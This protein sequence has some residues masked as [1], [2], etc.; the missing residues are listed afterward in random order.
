[1]EGDIL[2]MSFIKITNDRLNSFNCNQ[3]KIQSTKKLPGQDVVLT[4]FFSV[5]AVCEIM[6][7]ELLSDFDAGSELLSET[8]F[9][10]GWSVF[11]KGSLKSLSSFG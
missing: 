2:A 11:V 4:V 6:F 1:M 5:D 9:S 10:S 7:S 8:T 3:L